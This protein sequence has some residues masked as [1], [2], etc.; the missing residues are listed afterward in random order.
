MAGRE[1]DF[2][3]KNFKN[4]ILCRVVTKIYGIEYAEG[5]GG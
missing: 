5:L 1:G 3:L 4:V 2:G